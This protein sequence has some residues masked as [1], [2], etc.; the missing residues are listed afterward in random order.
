MSSIHLRLR[1]VVL[2]AAPVGLV[3]AIW[4]LFVPL[5]HQL[6]VRVFLRAGAAA[7]QGHDIYPAL[8]T[9]SVYSGSAF[10]YP[11]VVVWPFALLAGL[12]H[13]MAIPV[14]FAV[15]AFGVI[16]ATSFTP[17]RDRWIPVLVLSTA[18]TITGLQLGAISPLLFVG[19]VFLWKLRDRPLLFG[20]VAAPVIVSKL[21]LA[22][23]LIWP[24][25][26]KRY[27]ALA[28]ASS[29]T[30]LLLAFGFITGALTPPGYLRLLSELATHEAGAGFG[31]IGALRNAG[32]TPLAAQAGGLVLAAVVVVV[33][34][35]H[36]RRGRDERVLYCAGIVC[37]LLL[38][39][40]LWSHYLVLLPAALVALQARR[41]WFLALV[42]VSW[43]MAPP[44]GLHWT[45][46]VPDHLKSLGPVFALALLPLVLWLAIRG[47]RPTGAVASGDRPAQP[48]RAAAP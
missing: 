34:W 5:T 40:V 22:P 37:A 18:F 44:H 26:A 46:P 25:V 39:P 13:P 1:T 24:L 38:T 23:L 14:Y 48:A 42:V 43:V 35:A 6:D 8:G 20:L 12:P 15:C 45:L 30:L 19:A 7:L 3:I 16:A 36:Y 11:A 21:F 31:V 41:R 9:P 4:V 27:R 28:W 32:L 2:T 10:V 47:L 29:L 17:T 33:A